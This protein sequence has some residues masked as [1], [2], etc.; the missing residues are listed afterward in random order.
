MC[1]QPSEIDICVIFSLYFIYNKRTLHAGASIR[2]CGD[3]AG[4]WSGDLGE[5]RWM[6]S[7]LNP[8]SDAAQAHC[9]ARS[10]NRAERMRTHGVLWPVLA[11][12]GLEYGDFA[13]AREQ[14]SAGEKEGMGIGDG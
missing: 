1:Y 4:S 10:K 5:S 6:K 8:V 11:Y 9:L 13:E 3:S 12:L 14:G 7:T 2:Q